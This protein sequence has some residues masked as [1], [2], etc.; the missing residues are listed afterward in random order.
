MASVLI[1]DDDALVRMVLRT[2]L[3]RRGL[4][5]TQAD[6]GDALLRLLGTEP[7]D[8]CIMDARMPGPALQD[9]V[10]RLRDV[11]PSLPIVVL[12]GWDSAGRGLLGTG[13]RVAAKPLDLAALD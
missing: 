3:E 5:V 1:A 2:A 12:T 11:A 13:V 4:T 8:L 10:D 9:R 7:Y 6:D